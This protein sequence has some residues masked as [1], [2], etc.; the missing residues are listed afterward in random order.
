MVNRSLF[1]TGAELL[2]HFG[3]TAEAGVSLFRF[4]Y[5]FARL[6]TKPSAN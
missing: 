5:F 3:Q 1:V 2:T 6:M 4:L